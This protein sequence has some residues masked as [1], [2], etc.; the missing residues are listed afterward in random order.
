MVSSGNGSCDRG[1]Y[2]FEADTLTS[3]EGAATVGEL[4]DDWGVNLRRGFHN[5]VHRVGTDAVSCGKSKGL[6]FREGE[7][8]LDLVAREDA[9]RKIT[10]SHVLQG[11]AG[12][13]C[14]RG[15]V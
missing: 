2:S 13:G 7:C 12:D 1:L 3:V 14:A 6:F 10:C 15:F 5:S 9:A 11:I 4:H 8:L